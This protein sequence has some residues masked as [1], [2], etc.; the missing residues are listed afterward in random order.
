MSRFFSRAGAWTS[1]RI[2][3]RWAHGKRRDRRIDRVGTPT[4]RALIV[5]EELKS[6]RCHSRENI[7]SAFILERDMALINRCWKIKR[8]PHLLGMSCFSARV[9]ERAGIAV[10]EVFG[11]RQGSMVFLKFLRP[12]FG[13]IDW[14]ALAAL[15]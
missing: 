12:F 11:R 4:K 1:N 5:M 15:R 3:C 8:P 14:L 13:V 10:L 9:V 6:R 2:H 7:P